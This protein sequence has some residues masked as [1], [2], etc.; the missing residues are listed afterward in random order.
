MLVQIL[1]RESA[2]AEENRQNV[3]TGGKAI[4]KVTDTWQAFHCIIEANI[5][6]KMCNVEE[7]IVYTKYINLMDNKKYDSIINSNRGT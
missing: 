3:I 7:C 1:W 4:P 5:K 2:D 6:V